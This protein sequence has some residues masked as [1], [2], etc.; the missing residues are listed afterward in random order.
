MK[1]CLY[2]EPQ[3]VAQLVEVAYRHGERYQY[4][5]EALTNAIEA[6]ATRVEF[7]IHPDLF[8]VHNKAALCI[9]DNGHG[10]NPDDLVT[11]FSSFGDSNKDIGLDKNFG[12]GAK[13]SILPWNHYGLVVLSWTEDNPD[14]AMI[15][16]QY[17]DGFYGPREWLVDNGYGGTI[18][19]TVITPGYDPELGIDWADLKPEWITDAGHG[20]ILVLLGNDLNDDT[21]SGDKNKNENSSRD[22]V[23]FLNERFLS[24]PDGITVRVNSVEEPTKAS[25]RAKN[26]D[27]V[28]VGK[29]KPVV[30]GDKTRT[31][32]QH[33]RL[34]HG[35]RWFIPD[36]SATG[37][38]D[39]D[40]HGTTVE[41]HLA[42]ED[43]SILTPGP[44]FVVEY[45]NE[46]YA[47][48]AHNTVYAGF[49]VPNSK[50]RRRLWLIVHPPVHHPEAANYGVLSD[51][52]R[53]SLCMHDGS[54]LPI[55]EW[56]NAFFTKMPPEIKH[57]NNDAQDTSPLRVDQSDLREALAKVVVPAVTAI[58][59]FTVGTCV[60]KTGP[61]TGV[62]GGKSRPVYRSARRPKTTK[63]SAHG[64]GTAGTEG[65]YPVVAVGNGPTAAGYPVEQAP[66][67]L[68]E[69]RFG[70]GDD[71]PTDKK[72]L[73]VYFGDLQNTAWINE[74]HAWWLSL[75]D[76]YRACW[77][78]GGVE[79]DRIVQAVYAEELASKIYH[80][81]AAA[82][83]EA[84]FSAQDI[85]TEL[86]TPAA[87]TT[88]LSGI[89]ATDMRIRRRASQHFGAGLSI[90]ES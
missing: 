16:L 82:T 3:A 32:Y 26:A 62:A 15:W 35:L 52:A 19:E 76:H 22:L 63:T 11:F 42:P 53:S 86:L 40:E 29:M 73:A 25:R 38:V 79:V 55:P 51:Q 64:G 80:T 13:A 49:G 21:I 60:R 23:N 90:A 84:G 57:A 36:G 4:A 20:T 7:G 44:K 5:R 27:T 54:P 68:P 77:P 56:Q 10:M 65:T 43:A 28:N 12:V 66:P 85:T 67:P 17:H 50:V 45:R 69:I 75:I 72:Y 48:T 37:T 61:Q 1:N 74:G 59:K 46:L 24:L 87:L 88:A 78:K 18:D 81:R 58:V 89:V 8:R 70:Y 83:T 31:V 71:F 30:S 6:D 14:G 34:V 39:V 9:F 41:W 47:R 33:P 2:V